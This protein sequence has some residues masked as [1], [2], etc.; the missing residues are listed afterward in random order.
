MGD[1][2][3]VVIVGAGFGGLAAAKRLEREDVDVTIVDRHNFHTFQPLLYQVATAGLNAA[4]VG[5]VVRGLFRRERHVLFRKD[6]VTGVD[7][8]CGQ[9]H[10]ASEGPIGFDHLVVAA[11]SSTNYFGVD[12][13]REHAFPLYSLEDAVRVRNHLLSLFEAADSDPTLIDDGVLNV[14]VVGGGPTG[15]EVS[16]ALVELIEK[17]LEQDFHDLDVHRARVVLVEQADRLLAPFSSSSQRYARRTLVR[18]GVEVRLGTAVRRITADHV[19]LDDGEVLR[20]R[21]VLWAA[22]VRAGRLADVLGAEQGRGGRIV[23]G[24]DLAVPDHPEAFAVG[25]IADIDDGAG[26][27]LPQLAQ[28]AIQGGEHVAEQILADRAGRPRTAFRYHDKG[29]MATI[30]RRAA[31]AE[32]PAARWT[33][34]RSRILHGGPAWL[35]WLGLH[36]VYLLG[37]RNRISVLANWAW[38]YLTWDRGPR[39][40][41]RPEVLPHSPRVEP[42]ARPPLDGPSSARLRD[43]PGSG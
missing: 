18:R 35:A 4:D 43:D 41:L 2:P 21:L 32:I 10:L 7:W 5:Y 31:V 42:D 37:V 1:R 26:G 3:K 23:V 29:I 40:I 25:D 6:E 20:S 19:E 38:N 14:V 39:L 13:A 12:G 22:G 28:V 30:G 34:G 27:R 16:G 33:G 36:L 8:G 11:G 9:I 24:A 15:V 17:V